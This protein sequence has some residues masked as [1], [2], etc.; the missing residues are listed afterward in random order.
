MTEEIKKEFNEKF[1]DTMWTITNAV[2]N[3]DY[4]REASE[5]SAHD[6]ACNYV[7]EVDYS[8]RDIAEWL[9]EKAGLDLEE[10]FPSD[11]PSDE[12]DDDD[13][14]EDDEDEE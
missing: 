4:L 13:Y 5:W 11:Y 8:W 3:V 1:S 6:D 9:A 7:E 12:E 14:D 2:S 10:L